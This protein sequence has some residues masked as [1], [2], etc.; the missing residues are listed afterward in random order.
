M[1]NHSTTGSGDE[2]PIRSTKI[3]PTVTF[4]DDFDPRGL[5]SHDDAH[6]STYS[7]TNDITNARSNLSPTRRNSSN[8]GGSHSSLLDDEDPSRA[9]RRTTGSFGP[10]S[11]ATRAA[12]SPPYPFHP[13]GWLFRFTILG[14]VA[15][16]LLAG[17]FSDETIGATNSELSTGAC[18]ARGRPHCPA[19][20]R[21]SIGG[22]TS[23]ATYYIAPNS[24]RWPHLVAHH[25][26]KA[27][28][29]IYSFI[30][31]PIVTEY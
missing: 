3:R 30:S 6:R 10:V 24:L 31:L 14:T 18:E 16:I 15:Y 13:T 21:G 9:A 26:R 25:W 20:S 22:Q 19:D 17:Y 11:G 8:E 5:G 2:I 28:T 23:P 29:L 7:D 27:C 4:A 1:S 12:L